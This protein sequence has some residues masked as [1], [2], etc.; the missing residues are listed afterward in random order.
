LVALFRTSCVAL[1]PQEEVDVAI[2]E[3]R[4][5]VAEVHPALAA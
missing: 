1:R 5:V 3:G 4:A 2:L